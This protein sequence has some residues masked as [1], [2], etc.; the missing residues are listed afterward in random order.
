[1][2]FYDQL[3]CTWNLELWHLFGFGQL[4]AGQL[5]FSDLQRARGGTH[6]E[7]YLFKESDSG[8]TGQRSTE[9]SMI[10]CVGCYGEGLVCSGFNV[11]D[12]VL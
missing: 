7:V 6:C 9:Q 4:L 3:S 2:I 1:M 11:A 5:S 8:R 12:G 10:G